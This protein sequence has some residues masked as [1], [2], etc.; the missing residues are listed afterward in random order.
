MKLTVKDW[1]DAADLFEQGAAQAE[2]ASETHSA[3]SCEYA[4]ARMNGLAMFA[5]K[6]ARKLE[7]SWGD[8]QLLFVY[9]TLKSGFHNH[10]FLSKAKFVADVV[11]LKRYP[12]I[13]D[14]LPY[15]LN[16]PG[17]GFNVEGE[18]YSVPL[19]STQQ[20][21]D[22]L[23]GHPNFYERIPITVLSKSSKRFTAQVFFL[24]G[25]FLKGNIFSYDFIK[26]NAVKSYGNN[27]R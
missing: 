1:D 14:G 13:V 8:V 25:I 18:L 9:G 27:T 4:T 15:L 21:I 20:E 10:R 26:S 7:K 23:E 5:T 19:K 12:L 3:I 16:M 22:K 11:T 6:M 2:Q 17:N 24:K